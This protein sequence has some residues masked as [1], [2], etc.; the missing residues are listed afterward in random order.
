MAI[1]PADLS[2]DRLENLIRNHRRLGEEH[3][4]LFRMALRE[5]AKRKGK[6]L[7]FDKSYAAIRR[8]AAEGRY[9][10][11][12][13]LADESGAVWNR[14]RHAIGE[15]LWELVE[16][17]HRNGWPML[18][19]VVVNRSNVATGRMEPDTLRGFIRAA[20]DLGYVVTDEEAFLKEQQERV[21]AWAQESSPAGQDAQRD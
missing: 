15:H 8:A 5:R 9:L 12:K 14:V 20:R 19:A 16:Y 6:G 4:D 21:F 2:D 13:E 7:D 18:S 17:A 1:N 3:A 11:Y 10:S